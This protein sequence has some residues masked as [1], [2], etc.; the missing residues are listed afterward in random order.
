MRKHPHLFETNARVFLGRLSEKYNRPLT[1]ASVPAR[2]WEKIKQRGF[3]L[4][5][6]MGVWERSSASRKI[7]MSDEGLRR[8]FKAA[9]PELRNT[10]IAG[11]PYAVYGY[12][13][14]PALGKPADLPEL[15]KNLNQAGL[16]LILDFVPNH[17]AVDHPWTLQYPERFVRGAPG[18]VRENPGWFFRTAKGDF[19]AHGRD[20]Y[21]P[22]WT[23]TA[24]V[25]FFSDDMRVALAE[26][27]VKISRVCDGVR[28]DMAMLGLHDIFQRVWGEYL[29]GTPRPK[30]EFWP[31]VIRRVKAETPGFLFLAE[32]YW[33]LEWTLYKLGFDFTY[34]K[35]LY[36]RLKN[37]SPED[38]RGHLRAEMEYQVQ[39][40]RFIENHDEVRAAAAMGTKKACA[41]AVT[42]LTVP[43]LRMVFD[44]QI[45][46]KK[47][48]LPIQLA[49]EPREE[50]D[51]QAKKFYD[52]LL[53][54]AD[55][56]V[57]H[58]GEWRLLEVTPVY[59]GDESCGNVIAW[60]W[61]L[62]GEV[63]VVAVNYSDVP[64][65]ARLAVKLPQGGFGQTV[66]VTDVLSV[67][68]NRLSAEELVYQGLPVA[69][70]PWEASIYSFSV[71][72]A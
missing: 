5:W 3:D 8:E 64:S 21:F 36:D 2:E 46:G 67:K 20:P 13:L 16:G 1:L 33:D 42:A 65:H 34:D 6:L 63:R 26:E 15:K 41:A 25:N 39:C 32:V 47:I 54:Q 69:F 24:Q 49:R 71:S 30:D 12:Q 23:D 57:F 37:S 9:L 7:C 29:D 68:K 56:R 70:S 40:V 60:S 17:L 19:L 52:I 53:R 11:S 4:L 18:K 43:G 10:D 28:C 66:D 59:E 61:T 31:E 44:G 62:G 22:P 55:D 38:I 48:K 35:R 14:D 45:K 51:E 50:W 58:D 27:L 72:G